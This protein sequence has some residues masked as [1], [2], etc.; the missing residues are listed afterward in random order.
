M[1]IRGGGRNAP[2]PDGIGDPLFRDAFPMGHQS[3]RLIPKK[4]LL[5]I[6]VLSLGHVPRGR[7]FFS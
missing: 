5:P 1:G 4:A 6:F 2:P 3:A 7:Y